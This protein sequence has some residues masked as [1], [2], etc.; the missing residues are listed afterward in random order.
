M[1]REQLEAA[2]TR[3]GVSIQPANAQ[4]SDVR[5]L[6][7]AG[8]LKMA[9]TGLARH[10]ATHLPEPEAPARAVVA[11]RQCVDAAGRVA[12]RVAPE[13]SPEPVHTSDSATP[14]ATEPLEH[15][16]LGVLNGVRLIELM[17]GSVFIEPRATSLVITLP[18]AADHASR[19]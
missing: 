14:G 11:L 15:D 7:D 12:L 9:L 6:G 17:G 18:A 3:R 19:P 8:Y 13:D 2:L 1:A 10:L 4:Q 16:E 5:A